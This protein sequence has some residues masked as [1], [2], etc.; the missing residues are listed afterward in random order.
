MDAERDRVRQQEQQRQQQ[1][2]KQWCPFVE[3][4]CWGHARFV[5]PRKK[6]GRE[7]ER[8]LEKEEAA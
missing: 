1:Q 8:K 3:I 4:D 6:E 5:Q 2:Q 7:E